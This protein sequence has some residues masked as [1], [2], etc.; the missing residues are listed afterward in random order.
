MLEAGI[1]TDRSPEGEDI[2]PRVVLTTWVAQVDL[3]LDEQHDIH[4]VHHGLAGHGASIPV[5]HVT[6]KMPDLVEETD[7]ERQVELQG[8]APSVLGF[9]ERRSGIANLL[10][11]IPH[12]LESLR[13]PVVGQ[14]QGALSNDSV[15]G[16]ELGL[17]VAAARD[18][19]ECINALGY[20]E[21]AKHNA[22]SVSLSLLQS[23][24]GN[25]IIPSRGNRVDIKLTTHCLLEVGAAS[26]GS[27]GNL[28]DI[29]VLVGPKPSRELLLELVEDDVGII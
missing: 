15:L 18:V 2:L 11:M 22:A 17:V 25:A 13:F 21:V 3:D 26:E 20:R 19:D 6:A 27:E 28:Q 12:E 29:L 10:N 1:F 4:L 9:P 8:N 16:R 24:E 14:R 23:S 5:D 7:A